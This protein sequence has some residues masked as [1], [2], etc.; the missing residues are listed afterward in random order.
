[1]EDVGRARRRQEGEGGGA[2][3][4]R[5]ILVTATEVVAGAEVDT[6]GAGD[7]RV[8]VRP[9]VRYEIRVAFYREWQVL[10]EV[11]RCN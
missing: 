5:A 3:A 2:P 7:D 10:C 9:C 8:T 6:E 4:T 11:F 1:M